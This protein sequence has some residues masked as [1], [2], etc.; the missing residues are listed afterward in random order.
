MSN[1]ATATVDVVFDQ[2]SIDKGL[3]KLKSDIGRANL[4]QTLKKIEQAS[5]KVAESMSKIGRPLIVLAGSALKPLND[6]LKSGSKDAKELQSK[7]DEVGKASARLGGRLAKTPVFGKNAYEWAEKLANAIDQMD[8]R[9]IAKLIELA[10]AWQGVTAG[11]NLVKGLSGLGGVAAQAFG[12]AIGG[13]VAAAGTY[14]AGR[15]S[16][17][18]TEAILQELINERESFRL[19]YGEG[20]NL[21]L[22]EYAGGS[23]FFDNPAPSATMDGKPM[24]AYTAPNPKFRSASMGPV[25]DISGFSKRVEPELSM[26]KKNVSLSTDSFR[27]LARNALLVAGT[28]VVAYQAGKILAKGLNDSLGI[29]TQAEKFKRS[30]EDGTRLTN[31]Y[32]KA[33]GNQTGIGKDAVTRSAALEKSISGRSD[34]TPNLFGVSAQDYKELSTLTNKVTRELESQKKIKAEADRLAAYYSERMSN[35]TP[36]YM[37][38]YE[39]QAYIAENQNQLKI[40]QAKSAN[41]ASQINDLTTALNTLSSASQ[42]A[43]QQ[44]EERLRKEDQ[45]QIELKAISAKTWD[46]QKK[47]EKDIGD[48]KVSYYDTLKSKSKELKESIDSLWGRSI[49][50]GDAA[51]LNKMFT[52]ATLE[53]LSKREEQARLISRGVEE[54]TAIDKETISRKQEIESGASSELNALREEFKMVR[55]TIDREYEENKTF[56]ERVLKVLEGGN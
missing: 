4:E 19:G 40:E 36:S 52:Q 6:F 54:R 21:E 35:P 27:V 18:A 7:L 11:A 37:D 38:K 10:I 44:V 12:G 24:L 51:S 45:V 55:G 42:E 29:V 41:A 50:T 13:G 23:R 26:W 31:M 39:R 56:K 17:K 14:V 53:G 25:G 33:I 16:R 48:L 46:I 5:G 34:V 32:V 43:R 15:G 1:I 3:N 47:Q 30:L 2:K 28:F 8:E 22:P 49:T 9:K 20:R